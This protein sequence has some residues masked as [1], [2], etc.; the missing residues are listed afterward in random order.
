MIR[1]A[2]VLWRAIPGFLVLGTVDGALVEVDGPGAEIWELLGDSTT[3]DGIAV[4]LADRY[5]AP[6]TRVRDDVAH[7]VDQLVAAGF[8]DVDG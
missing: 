6:P 8:V 2:D 1:R 5:A 3:V 4:V 7:V